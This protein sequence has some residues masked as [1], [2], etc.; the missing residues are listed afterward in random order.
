[1]KCYQH[2]VM[3]FTQRR[4][5]CFLKKKAV[6]TQGRTMYEEPR[7][8]ECLPSIEQAIREWLYTTGGRARQGEAET[9]ESEGAPVQER[10]Q[11]PRE[12]LRRRGAVKDG[13]G[14]IRRAEDIRSGGSAGC[15]GRS[16]PASWWQ[17][18]V[19]GVRGSGGGWE[20][21]DK[22]VN[23]TRWKLRTPRVDGGSTL[24]EGGARGRVTGACVEVEHEGRART[25]ASPARARWD[26][27]GDRRR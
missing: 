2:R 13:E 16:V 25:R 24:P 5:V 10:A 15:M 4:G 18:A 1:M 20:L 14:T 7:G 6:M 23:R 21:W 17:S 27:G 12:G 3:P 11:T 19:G 9:G 8:G 26:G 22:K